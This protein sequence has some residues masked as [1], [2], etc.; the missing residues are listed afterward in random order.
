MAD[1]ALRQALARPSLK[2][3]LQPTVPTQKL[4]RPFLAGV[5][6]SPQKFHRFPSQDALL[7]EV[8]LLSSPTEPLITKAVK[9]KS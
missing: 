8:L 5:P 7:L 4:L 2:S 3:L 1:L 9:I 6:P